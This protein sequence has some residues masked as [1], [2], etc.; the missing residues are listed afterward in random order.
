M[1]IEK[2]VLGSKS[3]R[4]QELVQHLGYPVEIRIQ[5]IEETYPETLKHEEVPEYL[6][7]LKAEA[8]I[9]S[10]TAGE[11]LITSDTIVILEN[12]VLGKPKDE[13]DAIAMLTKLS[14]KTHLVISGVSLSSTTKQISFKHTTEVTFRA[15]TNDEITRYVHQYQPLDKAGSYGIQEW[16]GFI[17][18]TSI[19]GSYLNVV[20]LPV[21]DV[22]EALS[23]F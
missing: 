9:P 16:I 3:P 5:D 19:K 18:I 17:G 1:H 21:A 6:A 23:T 2:I 8:L 11:V 22:H 14:G 7:K 13:N 10:L 15:L 12:E 20:G 4:R